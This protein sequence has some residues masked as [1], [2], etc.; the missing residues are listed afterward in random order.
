M[1]EHLINQLIH[2]QIKQTILR[3]YYSKNDMMQIKVQYFHVAILYYNVVLA[4]YKL[5]IVCN[6]VGVTGIYKSGCKPS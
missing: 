3:P 1:I 5:Y 6:L 4:L 2:R